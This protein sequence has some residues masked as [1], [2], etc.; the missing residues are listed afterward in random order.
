MPT[1]RFTQKFQKE[2]RITPAD[3]TQADESEYPFP[4]MY[5]LKP[6]HLTAVVED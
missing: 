1:I 4:E 2:I 6:D 3:L 5:E